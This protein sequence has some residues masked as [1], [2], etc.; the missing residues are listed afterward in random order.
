[1]TYK[2]NKKDIVGVKSI[3][4]TVAGAPCVDRIATRGLTAD[5]L[6]AKSAASSSDS[7]SPPARCTSVIKGRKGKLSQT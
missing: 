4:D 5:L 2:P 7:E 1:M 6:Y 3:C